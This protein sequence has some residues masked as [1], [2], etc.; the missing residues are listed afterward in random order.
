MVFLFRYFHLWESTL[1]PWWSPGVM[2]SYYGIPQ[3]H[4]LLFWCMRFSTQFC[5]LI[6]EACFPSLTVTPMILRSMVICTDLSFLFS[7]IVRHQ[8][9]ASYCSIQQ[10]PVP[11]RLHLYLGSDM[12]DRLDSPRL[13]E[14]R[15]SAITTHVSDLICLRIL[16]GQK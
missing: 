5:L 8:V 11:G 1:L 6:Q 4:C 15:S 12:M 13:Y 3:V 7:C 9:F 16:Y 10:I 14:T 2:S